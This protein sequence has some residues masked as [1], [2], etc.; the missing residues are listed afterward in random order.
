MAIVTKT[1][2]TV[3]LSEGQSVKIGTKSYTM[4]DAIA[5]VMAR[6]DEL[7][8]L[9]EQALSCHKFIGEFLLAAK[10]LYPSTKEFGAFIASTDLAAMSRQDRTDSMFIAAN[11]TKV[12][13]LN[14][15]GKLD[16]LGVSA[17]RKRLSAADKPKAA[18]GS[19]GNV[20]KGKKAEAAKAD[21][22]KAIPVQFNSVEELAKYVVSACETYGFNPTDFAKAYAKARAKA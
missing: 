3:T 8:L 18:T 2:A 5:Q 17:I 15:D 1:A 14:K 10:S 16:Q 7:Y 22:A 21:A 4:S 9:Q 6:Y 13:K 20:S 11:W 12:Q 19:A